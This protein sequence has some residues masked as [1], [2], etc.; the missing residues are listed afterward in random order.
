[1]LTEAIEKIVELAHAD[2]RDAT[3]ETYDHIK[4]E[5]GEI[6]VVLQRGPDGCTTTTVFERALVIAEER[7]A[8]PRALVAVQTL[9][10]VDSF[11]RYVNRFKNADSAIFADAEAVKLR[12]VLDFHAPSSTPENQRWGRHRA[13]YACPLSEPWKRWTAFDGK[14]MSQ[15]EF[16]DFIDANMADLTSPT[17]TDVDVAQPAAVLEMA[18]NLQVRTKGAFERQVN[19]TTGESNFLARTENET[20]STKIYRAFALKLPVFRNGEPW[21]VEAR[22]RFKLAEQKATFSYHLHQRIETIEHAFAEVCKVVGDAT[23]LPIFAAPVSA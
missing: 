20:T 18:R 8:T 11:T 23:S 7:R 1:M 4:V 5:D 14:P 22:I 21:R 16:A 17:A 3:A 12:A 13:L 19:Q 6:P 15:D 2:T 10:D 9:T